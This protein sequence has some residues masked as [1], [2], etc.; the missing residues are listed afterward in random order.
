MSNIATV[1]LTVAPAPPV[2]VADTVTTAENT[3]VTFDELANDTGVDAALVP[4]SV[5]IVTPPAQ[6]T[7]TVDP[8][9][10]AITYT[11]GLNYVGPDTI[12]YTVADANGTV[13]NV[14]TIS[15]STTF[16]DYPPVA[17]NVSAQTNPGTAVAIHVLA[18]DTDPNNDIAP[19]TVAIGTGPSN[20]TVAVDPTT[21]IV[22][23]T[24]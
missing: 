15:L 22:T 20:G 23:Y 18:S 24:P 19:G 16:V 5:V 7:A 11:P 3:P 9:T 8:T 17:T 10:G 13:S 2:A 6:G 21:G 4:G 1:S 14:A 12:Q